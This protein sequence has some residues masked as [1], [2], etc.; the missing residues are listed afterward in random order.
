MPCVKGP[1][2]CG[3]V[4]QRQDKVMEPAKMVDPDSL[5]SLLEGLLWKC[6]NDDGQGGTHTTDANYGTCS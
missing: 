2:F 6:N 3:E 5:A 1:A 4:T